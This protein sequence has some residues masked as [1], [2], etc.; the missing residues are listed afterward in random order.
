MNADLSIPIIFDEAPTLPE[1]A[2][3]DEF[4]SMEGLSGSRFN[5]VLKGSNT[6]AAERAA[7]EPRA[8]P[9]AIRAAPSTHSPSP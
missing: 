1:N 4:E 5:D 3:L 6:L 9:K 7:G 2:A 8:A